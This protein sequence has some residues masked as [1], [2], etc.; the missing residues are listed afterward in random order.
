MAAPRATMDPAV[1]RMKAAKSAPP[2]RSSGTQA[3]STVPSVTNASATAGVTASRIASMSSHGPAPRRYSTADT[4]ATDA[5]RSPTRPGTKDSPAAVTI[6]ADANPMLAVRQ[7][8]ACSLIRG[9]ATSYGPF[10]IPE[11]TNVVGPTR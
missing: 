2:S 4:E 1:I 6:V 8:T 9:S 10:Q 3:G 11:D 5:P 7:T